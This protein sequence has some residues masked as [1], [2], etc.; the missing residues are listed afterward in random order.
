MIEIEMTRLDKDLISF[1][2]I[3]LNEDID[4]EYEKYSRYERKFYYYYN[5]YYNYYVNNLNDI[6]NNIDSFFNK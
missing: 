1:V 5:Y 2:E 4:S 3:S 6:I